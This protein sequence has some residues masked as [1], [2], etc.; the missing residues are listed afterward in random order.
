MAASGAG[1]PTSTSASICWRAC[2]TAGCC[3]WRG[4]TRA[5]GLRGDRSPAAERWPRVPSRAR[6]P[7]ARRRGPALRAAAGV[8]SGLSVRAAAKRRAAGGRRDATAPEGRSIPL[9]PCPRRRPAVALAAGRES[10]GRPAPGRRPAAHPPA[11]DPLVWDRRR[12]RL[13]WGWEYKLEAYLPAPAPNGPLRDAHTL[14]RVGPGVG[15]REVRR[16][17]AAARARLRR[18]SSARARVSAGSGSGTGADARVPKGSVLIRGLRARRRPRLAK[19]KSRLF[20]TGIEMRRLAFAALFAAAVLPAQAAP[21]PPGSPFAAAIDKEVTSLESRFV[22][23][24]EAMPE[25]K[26]DFTPEGLALKD[27]DFQGVRTFGAQVRCRRGQLLH[28]GSLD[29]QAR[30]GRNRRAQRAGTNDVASRDPEVPEGV[31][32]VRPPGGRPAH[33]AERRRNRRVPRPG[34]HPD[35]PRLPRSDA[36]DGPLRTDGGVSAHVRADFAGPPPRATPTPS[37][38]R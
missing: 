6:R 30:A 15:Q 23:L 13:F 27:S 9:C 29:R 18:S 38:G 10:P 8:Q 3:A 2:T 17:P 28:L 26:F 32:C 12:F 22:A 31:V 19:T 33:V 1:A 7:S 11:L 37:A 25:S 16:R 14:G 5:H 21:A 36:R 34:G 20:R 24:A 4:A 35:F